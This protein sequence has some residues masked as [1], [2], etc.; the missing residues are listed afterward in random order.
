MTLSKIF[1]SAFIL[2]SC[3]DKEQPLQEELTSTD[4]LSSMITKKSA[5]QKYDYL[6]G[7][8]IYY[9]GAESEIERLELEKMALHSKL[10][11]GDKKVI[12]QIEN[13]QIQI[14]KLTRFKTFL[15]RQK[16]ILGPI[17]P[18]PPPK[19]CYG[20]EENNCYPK[21]KLSSNTLIILGN[22]LIVSNV[23]IKN[24]KN[25]LL[26]ASFQTVKD[27]FGQSALQ[28]QSGFDGEGIMYTTLK[29]EVVGE[30]TIPTSVVGL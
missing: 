2:L 30:I 11:S 27:Q 18:I 5:E 8:Q 4:E 19:P 3:S 26:D 16:P 20:G 22:E 9:S 28:L 17:G 25:Q 23:V 12:E 15:M 29:T 21:Q 14:E 24:L 1:L 10:E 7:I 6:Y 13:N